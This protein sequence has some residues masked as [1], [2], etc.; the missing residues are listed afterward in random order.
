MER[1][2]LRESASGTARMVRGLCQ[3]RTPVVQSLS[4]GCSVNLRA[5]RIRHFTR[6]PRQLS[7]LRCRCV[8]IAGVFA[9]SGVACSSIPNV[10]HI[11]I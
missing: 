6:F 4:R 8:V 3:G 11:P 2:L 9:E 5:E 10:S 7:R 1:R